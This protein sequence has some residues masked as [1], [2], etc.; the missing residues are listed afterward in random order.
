M[1][2]L[3]ILFLFL[4]V[5]NADQYKIYYGDLPVENA[6]VEVIDENGNLLIKGMT[7]E[8]GIVSINGL[9]PGSYAGH[10]MVNDKIYVFELE[11]LNDETIVHNIHIEP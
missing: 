8:S 4:A 9:T 10:I 2:S 1:N 6:V 7:D 3:L 5:T 11:Y